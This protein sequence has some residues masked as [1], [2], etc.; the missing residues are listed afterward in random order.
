MRKTGDISNNRKLCCG[1]KNHIKLKYKKNFFNEFEYFVKQL[2][3][4][5]FFLFEFQY[6]KNCAT[7]IPF[8]TVAL[9]INA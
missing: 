3:Y 5:T 7:K 4:S 8:N 9:T 1:E 6:N 2:D